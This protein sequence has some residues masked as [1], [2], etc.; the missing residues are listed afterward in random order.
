MLF[1]TGL[2]NIFIYI[3]QVKTKAKIDKWD[4]NFKVFALK[5]REPLTKGKDN[6]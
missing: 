4:L 1:N 5:Q 6:H 2:S 3:S